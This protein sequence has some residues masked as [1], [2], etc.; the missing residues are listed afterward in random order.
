MNQN[1]SVPQTFSMA[2]GQN[3]R[4]V[5]ADGYLYVMEGAVEVYANT[6]DGRLFLA[7]VPKGGLFVAGM[8][9]DGAITVISTAK[10]TLRV[11]SHDEIRSLCA[12]E[13]ACADIAN[14]M[15]AWFSGL[16]EG[17]SK[18]ALRRPNAATL[19]AGQEITVEE[20]T[21]V[22]SSFGPLWV[23]APWGEGTRFLDEISPTSS[24]LFLL[25]PHT[26]LTVE[27]GTI[28]AR[29]TT[30]DLMN[31]PEV[32]MMF[33]EFTAAVISA[34]LTMAKE[35]REQET[36]RADERDEKTEEDLKVAKKRFKGILA[37]DR[38]RSKGDSDF[39]FVYE[40]IVK[41]KPS[42]QSVKGASEF[43]DHFASLN[44]CRLRTLDLHGEWWKDD[45]GPLV[46]TVK[47]TG[48]LV[49]V[50]PDWWGNY[51]LHARAER[52]RKV[53][54]EVARTLESE[55]KIISVPLPN[56]ELRVRD[57][58]MMGLR[59]C[60][61]DLSTLTMAT[62]GASLLGLVVPLATGIMID[63]FIPGAMRSQTLMLG[64]ALVV[65][66]LCSGALKMAS[67]YCQ[68]RMNSRVAER[69]SSGV[70]DRVM[71]LPTSMTRKLATVDLSMRVSAVDN[72]RSTIM[73]VVLNAL[74]SGITGLTGVFVLLYYS[75]LAGAI[76]AGLIAIIAIVGSLA[77]MKQLKAFS[78]GEAMTASVYTLT[79]QI[80]ENITILRSFAAERR[81]FAKWA[82]NSAE[83]RARGLRAR[84]VSNIF[85]AFTAAY[86]I[87]AV[88]V[89]FGVLGFTMGD[90]NLSTGEL[91][92]FV[93]TFQNFL[94]AGMTL[95]R[96]ANQLI[97]MKPSLKRAEP[98]LKNLP[99][100][101]P[102][103]K[104]PGE[105]S[106]A[107]EVSNVAF[108]HEGG[109]R[110]F[111]SVSF[112][113]S[114]GSFVGIVGPSGS[115]KSTLLA[116][117]VGFE[118]PQNGAI[119]YDGKDLAGLEL[120]YLRKQIGM[121]RQNGRLFAGSLLEN[122]LGAKKGDIN[123]AW[124]SA[125]LSGI[126]EDIRGL[127]M[128]MHTVI[129]EGAA[130][131]SGGQIQRILLARALVG[132]PKLLMLDEATSALDN[133]SQSAISKNIDGLGATRVVVAHRLSSIQS[134]DIILYLDGG[135]VQETGTYAELVERGGQF[136]EFA[137]RQTL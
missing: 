113:V 13:Q 21:S 55:A 134:A 106:G 20:P 35:F 1:P 11:Y 86:Q 54:A 112:R 61:M 76:A 123:D 3:A 23:Q 74:M 63:T 26:W 117:L 46:C 47:E 82:Q 73:G 41:E 62:L 78:E 109:V 80:I 66:Q 65:V 56:K 9:M 81:A 91:M 124:K 39:A 42:P 90:E 40:C 43:F 111:D 135:E 50:K 10:T 64:L 12:D 125:E 128:G 5:F 32:S 18:I 59:L 87:I 70:M 2:L 101:A 92:V 17:V 121:V 51:K 118:K 95:A 83:M 131:F 57:I 44:E 6:D 68:Q 108:S 19:T 84:N 34:A 120:S 126:A 69:I 114:P 97:G 115:G 7:E 103:A 127:P 58:I 38:Q 94:N 102:N 30:A 8:G 45:K 119:L 4:P 60:F 93:S 28:Q 37:T 105:L 104:A 31:M 89:I 136:A 130:A 99:E 36:E 25:T 71:R 107:I 85:E 88:A 15:D 129:T 110:V 33:G 14:G 98:I 79:Q 122:I 132:S 52:P 72:A 24:N 133:V 53:T 77:A 96:G 137:A 116:L 22:T 29:A 16:S 27:E 67:S 100:T 75:P 49:A 48:Q